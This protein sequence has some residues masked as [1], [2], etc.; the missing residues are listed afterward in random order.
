MANQDL[1]TVIGLEVHVELSTDSKAF[2]RCS[3]MFG[4]EPNT[5]ICPVCLG[6]PGGLPVLNKKVLEY[7]ILTGLA[8]NCKISPLCKFDRKNYFYP[9]MPNAFQIS[10]ADKPVAR[11]GYIDVA[12][13]GKKRRIRIN[14][15]HMEEDAGKLMHSGDDIVA[16]STSLV[17][18]NRAGC[19]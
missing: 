1:E 5:Q 16:A 13:Q 15:V 11:N 8:L 3:T 14:R 4:A 9:D 12:V 10:Q 19:P 18:L 17:D 7:A 6:L 2:C